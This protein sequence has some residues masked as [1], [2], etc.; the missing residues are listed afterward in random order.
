[1]T[2][3]ILENIP[4]GWYALHGTGST[5]GARTVR[6]HPSVDSDGASE[7][8]SRSWDEIRAGEE[9]VVTS[10][11]WL[12]DNLFASRLGMAGVDMET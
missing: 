11:G 12:L 1:V 3:H 4:C 5:H 10:G 9:A 8:L 6:L 2:R 7:C